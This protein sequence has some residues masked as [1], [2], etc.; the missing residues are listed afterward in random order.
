[1]LAPKYSV[2]GEKAGPILLLL[3]DLTAGREAD[4]MQVDFEIFKILYR[5]SYLSFYFACYHSNVTTVLEFH[6]SQ[7]LS[8]KAY[9]KVCF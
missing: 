7:L 9:F 6:F 3:V 2:L 5:L 4:E 1:M 8:S